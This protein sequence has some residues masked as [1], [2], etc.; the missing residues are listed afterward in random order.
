MSVV[1]KY[2]P[3]VVQTNKKSSERAETTFAVCAWQS[4]RETGEEEPEEGNIEKNITIMPTY[5][6]YVYMRCD[7]ERSCQV[8][9]TMFC[10]DDGRCSHVCNRVTCN[11]QCDDDMV[12]TLH[13]NTCTQARGVSP[14][15][16]RCVHVLK[17]EEEEGGREGGSV[18]RWA[19][20]HKQKPGGIH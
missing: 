7:K 20:T 4:I 18:G 5:T 2:P 3:A 8:K 17:E 16:C 11:M 10:R 6:T 15:A 12:G 19:T 9:V 14:H 1:E 13:E